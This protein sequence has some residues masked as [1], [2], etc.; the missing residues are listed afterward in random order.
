MGRWRSFGR[1]YTIRVRSDLKYRSIDRFEM[2]LRS[3][4][5][6]VHTLRG[7]HVVN[8]MLVVFSIKH[9][10]TASCHRCLRSIAFDSLDIPT[11]LSIYMIDR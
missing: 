2:L 1:R 5:L 9:E 4:R 10:P 11:A 7:S 6:G 8:G 3:G